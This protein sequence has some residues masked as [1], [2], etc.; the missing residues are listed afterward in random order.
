MSEYRAYIVGAESHVYACRKMVC[1]NDGEAV[2]GAMRLLDG[3]DIEVWQRERFVA[4]VVRPVK[5]KAVSMVDAIVGDSWT[6]PGTSG[7]DR[8]L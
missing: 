1:S 4:K 7:N 8:G 5:R 3:H 2:T 6:A